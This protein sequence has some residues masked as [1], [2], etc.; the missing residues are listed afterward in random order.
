M[1]VGRLGCW[2]RELEDAEE[3]I[4]LRFKASWRQLSC[5]RTSLPLPEVVARQ[6][7]LLSGASKGAQ[8]GYKPGVGRV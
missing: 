3:G 5:G 6:P 4:W 1:G 8:E 2:S 7:D